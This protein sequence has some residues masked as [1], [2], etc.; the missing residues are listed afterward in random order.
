MSSRAAAAVGRLT[1][2]GLPIA[3][4]EALADRLE[5]GQTSKSS[6]AIKTVIHR[7]RGRIVDVRLGRGEERIPLT[8]SP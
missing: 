7:S 1:A 5:G 3:Y 2:A 6:D 4:L 8:E